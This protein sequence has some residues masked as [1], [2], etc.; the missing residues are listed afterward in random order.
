MEPDDDRADID[1]HVSPGDLSLNPRERQQR[2]ARRAGR[3]TIGLWS[4]ADSE[5][6]D[7][8]I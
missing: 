6:P 2:E 5:G 8:P 7:A 4:D 3:R 1:D